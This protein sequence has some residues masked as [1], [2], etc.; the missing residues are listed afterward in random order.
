MTPST[1]RPSGRPGRPGRN[2]RPGRPRTNWLAPAVLVPLAAV[3]LAA[4]GGGSGGSGNPAPAGAQQTNAGQG[5]GAGR[6]GG[7]PPGVS[8]LIAEASKGTLEV[9]DTN[10]QTTVTYT[11][12]TKFSQTVTAKLAVGDCVTV[13]GTPVSGSTSAITATSVVVTTA[14]NSDCTAPNRPGGPRASGTPFPRPDR[15]A[16]P[17]GAPGSGGPGGGAGR[18][19]FA[20]AFGKVTAVSGSTVT[21]TGTLRTGGGRFGGTPTPSPSATPT[22]PAAGPLTVTLGSSAT[23][24]KTV[25]ATSAAAVTGKCASAFGKTDSSGTVAATTITI[26]TPGPNGCSRGFGGFGNFPGRTG[27]GG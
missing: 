20:T 18:Q 6:N 14:A 16:M 8:G 17:S 22:R 4:C 7:T 24:Q 5:T 21:I 2:R 27:G 13:I 26:S 10:S 3:L 19:N 11:A 15:S 12:G 1:F 23:V 9:Q 25:A